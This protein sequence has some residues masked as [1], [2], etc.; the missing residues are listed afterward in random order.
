MAKFDN[1]FTKPP[2]GHVGFPEIAQDSPLFS[3]AKRWDQILDDTN[4]WFNRDPDFIGKF[5]IAVPDLYEQ[6][7]YLINS[8]SFF[9]NSRGRCDWD[10][11][12]VFR[13]SLPST[14]DKPEQY[15]T[16]DYITAL[17]ELKNEIPGAHRLHTVILVTTLGQL[18]RYGID[19]DIYSGGQSDGQIKIIE[20]PVNQRL[21]LMSFRPSSQ[22]KELDK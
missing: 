22:Q 3:V 14:E 8:A 2:G 11:V 1:D 21:C 12:L 7:Q 10:Y 18:T 15:W 4:L 6:S 5:V 13:R 17:R 16:T 9:L 20:T 19:D